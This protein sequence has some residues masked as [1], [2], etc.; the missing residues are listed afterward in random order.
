M[1]TRNFENKI[2]DL[3]R[4]VENRKKALDPNVAGQDDEIFQLEEIEQ[5]LDKAHTE[6]LI[7]ENRL[8]T[9]YYN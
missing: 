6:I 1:D 9:S 3:M 2:D 8:K 4:E 7:Y 5:N